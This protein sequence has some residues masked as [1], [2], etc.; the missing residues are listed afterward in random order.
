MSKIWSTS[1]DEF[2]GCSPIQAL[3]WG[4]VGLI[5]CISYEFRPVF[6]LHSALNAC[7]PGFLDDSSPS[8]FYRCIFRRGLWSRTSICIPFRAQ[9]DLSVNVYISSVMSIIVSYSLFQLHSV[10]TK[11]DWTLSCCPDTMSYEN[12][13]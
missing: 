7:G 8:S 1:C 9:R 4:A 10:G 13:H 6:F 5:C 3:D 11:N 2:N 12:H